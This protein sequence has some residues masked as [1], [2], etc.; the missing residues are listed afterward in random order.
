MKPREFLKIIGS[1]ITNIR[2]AEILQTS[3]R[4]TAK[5]LSS[6]TKQ[7]WLLRIS[8]GLY[9]PQSL[10]SVDKS[11]LDTSLSVVPAIIG[12]TG[13]ICGWSAAEHWGITE[14]IFN[15]ISIA[16]Y[17][18]NRSK[19]IVLYNC[20]CFIFSTNSKSVIGTQVLWY[21]DQKV[22]IS[23]LHK[24]ILD[25]I[26]QP[27]WGGG[28]LHSVDCLRNYLT[29]EKRDVKQILDYAELVEVKGVF[30]KRLG[31]LL[32]IMGEDKKYIEICNSKKTSGYSPLDPKVTQG[33]LC[34]RWNLIIP[35]NINF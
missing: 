6:W 32:E 27:H 22:L 5:I 8:R 19:K 9:A 29:H 16:S 34:S 15:N 21:Q 17:K 1:N 13:Y 26:A 31:Y 30:Y 35:E 33:K 20:I 2:A 10:S 11:S 23:D 25:C 12:E 4:E 24:T 18:W 28:L 7:G 3:P 14:Q